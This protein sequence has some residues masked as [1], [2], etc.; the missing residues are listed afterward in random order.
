MIES[1]NTTN[2]MKQYIKHAI[3]LFSLFITYGC[4]QTGESAKQKNAIAVDLDDQNKVSIF[5]LFE[6]VEIIPLETTDMSLMRYI[7]KLIYHNNTIFILDKMQSII[8]AFDYTGKFKYKIDNKGAGPDQ[9]IHIS[10][11]DIDKEKALL[12]F[13]S[14]ASGELHEYNLEGHFSQKYKLPNTVG[15]YNLIKHLSN[16]TV[17]FWTFDYDNRIKF[18]SKENHKIFSECFPEEDNFFNQIHIQTFSYDNFLNR[19]ID[20]NTYEI[21]PEGNVS[22]AYTWDFNKLN[23]SHNK[24]D[25]LNIEDNKDRDIILNYMKKISSSEAINYLFLM[26]GGNSNFIYSQV[27]RKDRYKN[28]LHH[29]ANNK[30]L[31]FDETIEGAHFYPIYWTDDFVIGTIPEKLFFKDVSLNSVIPDIILDAENIEKKNKLDEFD[32]PILVRY[33]FKTDLK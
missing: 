21:L 2:I 26:S 7:H 17:A 9:Y 19:P 8:F 24:V 12:S 29:K 22:I 20:N 18:Y 30:T 32:N 10:D 25:I 6:K 11:F 4:N 28:I 1:S 33:Y 14:P 3:I 13:I 15:A 16:N 5:D 27:L 31:V 23:I